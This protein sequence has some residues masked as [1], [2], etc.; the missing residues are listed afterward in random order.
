MTELTLTAQDAIRAARVGGTIDTI[1]LGSAG[2]FGLEA[3]TVTEITDKVVRTQKRVY[4][5]RN[6][7]EVTTSYPDP[8]RVI[9]SGRDAAIYARTL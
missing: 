6:R 7:Q 3:E 1:A 5:A 9:I 4:C 2:P 8:F